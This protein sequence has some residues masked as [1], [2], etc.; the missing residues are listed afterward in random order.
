MR[1]VTAHCHLVFDSLKA[2][3]LSIVVPPSNQVTAEIVVCRNIAY[4][5]ENPMMDTMTGEYVEN[6]YRL[7]DELS[8]FG[9]QQSDE[10]LYHC[11]CTM[12]RWFGADNA[13]WVGTLRIAQGASAVHDPMSGWRIRT[14]HN[15]CNPQQLKIAPNKLLRTINEKSPPATNRALVA[16]AGKFRVYTLLEG[17]LVD[18]SAFK[19]TKHYD[20]Y[21]RQRNITDRMWVG[22]PASPDAESFFCFDKHGEHR[23]FSDNE[24]ALA[25][26]ALRG[27]KWFHRQVIMSHGIGLINSPLTPTE[28]RVLPYLLSGTTEKEIAEKMGVTPGTAH[29][30]ITTLFRKFGVHG[31]TDFMALWLQRGRS[32]ISASACQ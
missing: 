11:L 3:T 17:Q 8:D 25:A 10:A 28:R 26:Q 16:Q 7:W 1:S 32:K 27:I 14:V 6:I 9:L 4:R 5:F 30:Y 18:I 13:F 21:Y 12:R 31:R 20:H 2:S 19:Q 22:F 15:I 23:Y 29:Q 24:K